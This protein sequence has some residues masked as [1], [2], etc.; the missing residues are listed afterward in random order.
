[1]NKKCNNQILFF[2]IKQIYKYNLK[3]MKEQKLFKL[4]TNSNIKTTRNTKL[5]VNSGN[6]TLSNEYIVGDKTK[7]GKI[8]IMA[9]SILFIETSNFPSEETRN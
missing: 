7:S 8:E 1:M 6:Y 5:S 3:K 9:S 2:N 4:T